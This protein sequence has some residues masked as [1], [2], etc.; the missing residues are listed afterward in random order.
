M[1]RFQY[2]RYAVLIGCV[3]LALCLV[4]LA[5]S[6][7][8]YQIIDRQT[9]RDDHARRVAE[10][11]VVSDRLHGIAPDQTARSMTTSHLVAEISST[12]RVTR[13]PRDEMLVDIASRI[14]AWEPA[15]ADRALH[16]TLVPTSR[17]S[18]D[19]IGSLQLSDGTWLNFQSHDISTMWPVAW[20]ANVLT[21]VLAVAILGIGLAVLNR[22]GAPL[23]RLTNAAGA[24]GHGREVAIDESHGPR[25]LRDLA[26]AMNVM[27][28]RIARLLQDQA[29]SFEAISHD[30]RTPLARQ[31]IAATFVEDEEVA[32]IIAGSAT[33]MD[34]LLTSLQ[35]YLRAQ[36]LDAS[37]EPVELK[38]FLE[39]QLQAFGDAVTI[40]GCD[41]A[42]VTTYREPL[43]L[44][45]HALAEN[46]VRHAGAA[47]IAIEQREGAWVIAIADLGPGIPQSYFEAILQPF[48]RLDA[49]RQRNTKGFGLGIPTAHH[50]MMRFDGALTF[51]SPAGGG[52]VARLQVPVADLG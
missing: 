25:D 39:E 27:Q 35:N 17:N 32:A 30:L 50:L 42:W 29:R 45:V 13:R 34:D 18:K 24:I 21:F 43:A 10:L 1:P 12:P 44:A 8:F 48:F 19:L 46:A 22:L 11:L 38:T 37:P 49:A 40:A 52:L 31:K 41:D 2:P 16:L 51:E 47:Q 33:E 26:H 6:L 7:M 9:L 4:Q 3:F 20:R 36:H 28:E 14:V 5:G 23:R 15:L